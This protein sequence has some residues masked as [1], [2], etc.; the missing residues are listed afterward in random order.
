MTGENYLKKI[1]VLTYES[2]PHAD[3]IC[4]YFLKK[5]IK[6]FRVNTENII[7]NYKITFDSSS[8]NYSISED[9]NTIVLNEDW[10]IWNRRILEPIIPEDIPENLHDI[11]LTETERTWQGLIFSHKGK[12]V[13]SPQ[14]DYN[15][16]NKV[17][18]L[19]FTKNYG[20]GVKIPDTI[21]TN[22][23][24]VLKY[25]YKKNEKICHKLLQVPMV[26]KD[27]EYFG[28]YNN[29]ISPENMKHAELINVNPCLFQQYI[30]KKYELRITALKDKIIPIAIFSQKSEVSKIDFRRYDLKNVTYEKVEIPDNVKKF[31][32]DLLYHYNLSFAEIDIILDKEG[33][34]Y[35]L[36]INPKGQWLWLE[37]QSGYNLTK[38]VA[39]NLL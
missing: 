4:N 31:C 28:V 2:D 26:I 16:N 29:L 39:E 25:F 30:D 32:S 37:E 21:L 18:Q 23:P 24:S 34:Y 15:A 9:N 1:F 17:D 11:I 10:N 36:E 38:D 27:G 13:N 20:N 5:D 14:S 12:V 33:D 8:C 7:N 19:C 22:D 6:F 35:F 3:S